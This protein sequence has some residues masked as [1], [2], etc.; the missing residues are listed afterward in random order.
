[1]AGA[2]HRSCGFLG[3]P[4]TPAGVIS[5]CEK[6]GGERDAPSEAF[7]LPTVFSVRV[8]GEIKHPQD[9]TISHFLALFESFSSSF[10]VK[11]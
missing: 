11:Y 9:G 3:S 4:H 1:L 6:R 2:L 5:A 8:R 10:E 7:L